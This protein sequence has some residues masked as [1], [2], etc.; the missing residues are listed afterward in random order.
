MFDPATLGWPDG[1]LRHDLQHAVVEVGAHA[2]LLVDHRPRGPVVAPRLHDHRPAGPAAVDVRRDALG[3]IAVGRRREDLRHRAGLLVG[4]VAGRRLGE[5]RSP[6]WRR[7][8]AA[9]GRA[10]GDRSCPRRRP[11]SRSSARRSRSRPCRPAPPPQPVWKRPR[12]PGRSPLKHEFSRPASAVVPCCVGGDARRG[13]V[14]LV[15]LGLHRHLADPVLLVVL[16]VAGVV[17]RVG[18][19]LGARVPP[20][21]LELALELA[22]RASW[23]TSRWRGRAWSAPCRPGRRASGCS[24]R[25]CRAS[26]APCPAARRCPSPRASRRGRRRGAGRRPAGCAWRS[27]TSRRGSGCRR[28]SAR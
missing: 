21:A 11:G 28:S 1:H 19:L 20:G 6:R 24:R 26:R 18:V 3:G 27:R 15:E 23:P 12:L 8:S 4:R 9:A 7:C 10:R 2:E 16:H 5:H 17:Q 14:A 22:R 13:H 25:R